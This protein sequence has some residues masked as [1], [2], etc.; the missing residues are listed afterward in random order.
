MEGTLLDLLT[1][2]NERDEDGNGVAQGKADDTNT[3]EGVE[4]DGG[5]EVDQT[6]DKL[7]D[8]TEHHSVE[9][10][11]KLDVDDLPP[12][13]TRDSAI[14]RESPGSAR[15]RGRASDTTNEAENKKRD[16][17][18][19]SC[20]RASYCRLDDRGYWLAREEVEQLGLVGQDE[21]ERD[22][23]HKTTDGVER[24]G[25]DQRLGDLRSGVLYFFTH[26]K[27]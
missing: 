19:N 24:D 17:Q 18:R 16:E 2:A 7:D 20:T 6:K 26:P 5:S 13:E 25:A 27:Y 9:W 21:Y 22:Q 15:R 8:H 12:L 11:V 14:T 4:S 10:Y 1:A 23:E 3:R